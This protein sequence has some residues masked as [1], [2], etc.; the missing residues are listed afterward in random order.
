[1]RKTA[2]L[3]CGDWHLAEDLVQNA[4]LKLYMAWNRIGAHEVLDAYLRRT[5]FRTFLDH[6]RRSWRRERSTD[7]G[8][9]VFER[10]AVGV[11]V[12]E[13]LVLLRGLAQVPARQRAVLVLRFWE[14][15]SVDETADVLGCAVGTVK[16][17]SARGLHTLRSAL[18]DAGHDNNHDLE[19][20]R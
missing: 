2:Y 20:V 12:E 8:A 5:I 10:P 16:S 19:D 4:F 6:G 1:M 14:D 3:L 18:R 11:D 13:R 7:A 17:Q 9:G 15:L